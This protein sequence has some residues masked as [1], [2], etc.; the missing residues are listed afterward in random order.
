MTAATATNQEV[1]TARETGAITH[2][3]VE[4]LTD[5]EKTF[6]DI[7]LYVGKRYYCPVKTGFYAKVEN[8]FA[9]IKSGRKS[10]VQYNRSTKKWKLRQV[11]AQAGPS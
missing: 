9:R 5:G 6:D 3:I 8:C 2:L 1:L 10:A 4:A 7:F 11:E